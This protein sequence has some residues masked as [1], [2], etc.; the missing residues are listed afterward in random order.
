MLLEIFLEMIIF[1]VK[2]MNIGNAYIHDICIKTACIRDIYIKNVCFII[3]TTI[4]SV[5][6]TNNLLNDMTA[7]TDHIF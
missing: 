6:Y 1:D 4:W 5:C 7:G 3:D 2:G